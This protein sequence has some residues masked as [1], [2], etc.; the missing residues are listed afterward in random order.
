MAP[1]I[2]AFEQSP[3]RNQ[4]ADMFNHSLSRRIHARDALTHQLAE[5]SATHLEN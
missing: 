3:D 4:G 5:G 2:T 1:V